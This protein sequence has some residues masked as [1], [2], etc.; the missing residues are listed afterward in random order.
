MQIRMP[1]NVIWKACTNLFYKAN[2]KWIS[3]KKWMTTYKEDHPE[4][5]LSKV[6]QTQV[7]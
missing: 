6:T 1:S 7:F 2:L 5:K 3:W 4:E